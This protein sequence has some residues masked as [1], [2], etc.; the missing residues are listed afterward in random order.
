M[1]RKCTLPL[2]LPPECLMLSAKIFSLH[3]FIHLLYFDESYGIV[4]EKTKDPHANFTI[5]LFPY[6]T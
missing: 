6:S 5:P 4:A 1:G 3:E 2:K